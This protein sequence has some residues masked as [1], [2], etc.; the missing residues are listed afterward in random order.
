[1]SHQ[2]FIANHLPSKSSIT[3]WQAYFFPVEK[4]K[5]SSWDSNQV[6]NN[7]ANPLRPNKILCAARYRTCSHAV[8]RVNL[9]QACDKR[10]QKLSLFS[11]DLWFER[12]HK[13]FKDLFLP[14]PL[15]RHYV[16]FPLSLPKLHITSL[17]VRVRLST[18][19]HLTTFDVLR[20]WKSSLCY[21]WFYNQDC[22]NYSCIN[23]KNKVKMSRKR[24]G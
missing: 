10:I 14:N 11:S 23:G 3:A 19:G 15:H 21:R 22:L 9:G 24:M 13:T 2:D 5:L 18:N 12:R 7:L 1:M 20:Y 17:C 6:R 8:P 16:T 4:K